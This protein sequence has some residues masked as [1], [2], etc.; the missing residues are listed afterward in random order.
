MYF[1]YRQIE[2]KKL[3]K[4]L[5]V[6]T[7]FAI[8]SNLNCFVRVGYLYGYIFLGFPLIFNDLCWI[9]SWILWLLNFT[10]QGKFS[11]KFYQ[12]RWSTTYF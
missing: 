7:C 4:K 6:G 2:K 1:V 11:K 3:I 9:L 5:S 10:Y 12:L 8:K